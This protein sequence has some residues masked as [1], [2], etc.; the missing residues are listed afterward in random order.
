MVIPSAVQRPHPAQL[1]L[2]SASPRRREL[3]RQIGVPHRVVSADID[4]RR[5]P[6][7]SIEQCVQRLAHQKAERV[8]GTLDAAAGE[9]V[10][11]ADTA[12]LLGDQLLGKPADRAAALLMLQQ[13]SG[14]THRVLTAVA[15]QGTAGI[16][17]HLSHSEV[18]FR[19]LRAGEAECYWDSGEPRDKAGAYA[20]QGLAAA[21]IAELRGSYS[22]V[23]GLPLYETADLLQR[24]GVPLWQEVGE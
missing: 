19:V 20:I 24:A 4:E 1:V 8:F 16:S 23:M 14:R 21:F 12:V 13:L 17:S 6:G 7:E 2:A 9:V 3:L 22:G 5:L 11:A 10:L 15:L 18:R